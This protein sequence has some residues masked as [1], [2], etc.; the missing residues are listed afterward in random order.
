[1]GIRHR[2]LGIH[3]TDRLIASALERHNLAKEESRVAEQEFGAWLSQAPRSVEYAAIAVAALGVIAVLFVALRMRPRRVRVAVQA[4][5]NSP[6]N[7]TCEVCQQELIFAPN[8]LVPISSVEIGLVAR[9]HPKLAGRKLFEYVCPHCESSHTFIVEGGRPQWVGVNLYQPQVKTTRC[10]ECRKPLRRP[11]WPAGT[12]D[13]RVH[14][15]PDLDDGLG[16]VCSRCGSVCC[17]EC[18]RKATRTRTPDRTFLCPR[19]AR[20]P[21]DRLFHP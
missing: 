1:M 5:T 9:T 16:L 17:V 7:L 14:E 18:C 2:A 19:C 15:I 6:H 10:Q 8:A 12:H 11:P 13:G 4:R 20:G 3:A 21:V